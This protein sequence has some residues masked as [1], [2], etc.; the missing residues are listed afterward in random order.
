MLRRLPL[1]SNTAV[2]L[3]FFA[4]LLILSFVGFTLYD[5]VEEARAAQ[6][7]AEFTQEE[8]H[9][10]SD[11]M[12]SFARAESAQRGFL[13]TGQWELLQDR[14][15][16]TERAL[17]AAATIE[18]M[19]ADDPAQ[20]ARARELRAA[21]GQRVAAAAETAGQRAR[22]GLPAVPTQQLMLAHESGERFYAAATALYQQERRELEERQQEEVDRQR[23]AAWVL[24][25][26]FAVFLAV[27]IPAWL[28]VVH[29][30]GRRQRA[31]RQ[32]TELVEH[33]PATVW[34]LRTRP[35]QPSRYVYVGPNAGRDRG[36]APEQLLRDADSVFGNV[37]EE[38]RAMLQQATRDAESQGGY[39][40]EYRIALAD[41]TVRWVRSSA[42]IREQHDGSLLWTG[43][44]ADVSAQKALE[45]ALQ[46]ATDEANRANRAKSTFLATMSHEI[47]TPMNGVLGLLELLNLTRLDS[48]QR[49]TLTV[50]SESSRALLRI[51]DDILDFSKVEAGRLA[52]DPMPASVPEVISRACQIHSG[53]ASSRGL[54]LQQRVDPRVGPVLVFDPLRVGQ[55]LN[56]F[57]SN[58]LK[59]TREGS[60]TVAVE[61]LHRTDTTERVRFSV[62]DT[63][64]GI[65]ASAAGQLFEPFAQADIATAARFGGTGLGLAI[66]KRLAEMMGGSV[67]MDSSEGQGTTVSFEV[68]FPVGSPGDLLAVAARDEAP[69]QL[70]RQMTARRAAPGVDDAEREGR[71]VLVADDHPTNRLVLS[72][73]VAALGYGLLMAENGVEAMAL[74][75]KHRVG[76]LL[77]DCNMPELNGYDLARAIRVAEQ[78]QDR[79]R[80]PIVACTANALDNEGG[81]CLAAG[82]DDILIKPVNLVDL[83]GRL[84]QWLP[85]PDEDD[86]APPA[87]VAPAM[88]DALLDPGVLEAI[89]GGDAAVERE[90]LLDYRQV[91]EADL[92][93]L[94]DEV[95]DA[96]PAQALQRVHRI[97]GAARTVGALQVAQ[98]CEQ[99]EQALRGGDVPGARGALAHLRAQTAR[100]HGHIAAL[101]DGGQEGV[102]TA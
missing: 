98:A 1:P 13:L 4:A 40:S 75:R 99:L 50:V 93:V 24:G 95:V 60:V 83:M 62:I 20:H 2:H 87:P 64:I 96:D 94:V 10:M 97:K 3:S 6:R 12:E 41:G 8:L 17:R 47:R 68:E 88:R 43:Y 54:L 38:D 51:I 46:D 70:A 72:R 45:R 71:L 79:P 23:T 9:A 37:V 22:G 101:T 27:L 19:T 102:T 28:G 65:A 59:F 14:D 86:A 26:S 44:W 67:R 34:Q 74:W 32:M 100:L 52:L 57:I 39:Q 82:M 53:I 90:V 42:A 36:V 15:N 29:Q 49:A 35:Q 31:E 16:W 92:A 33:L 63:G 58:A 84:D 25:G 7:E 76:L 11:A 91:N 66:C 73:Q 81:R 55:I 56:N 85:L 5:T 69:R 18:M 80:T 30:A 21:L 89:T 48:E 77:T 78:E 61:Q